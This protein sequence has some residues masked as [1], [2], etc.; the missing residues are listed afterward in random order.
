MKIEFPE[1]KNKEGKLIPSGKIVATINNLQFGYG[2]NV[3]KL[4]V[5]LSII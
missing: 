3:R 2:N 4:P 1:P 5:L